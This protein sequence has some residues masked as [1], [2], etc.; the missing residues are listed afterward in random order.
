[1]RA[2]ALEAALGPLPATPLEEGVAGRIERFRELD[3]R[4]LL[5]AG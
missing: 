4:G 2:E 5:P 1:V 3:E